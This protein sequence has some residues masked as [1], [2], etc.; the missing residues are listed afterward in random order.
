MIGEVELLKLRELIKSLMHVIRVILEDLS[1]KNIFWKHA[2]EVDLSLA[3]E[4]QG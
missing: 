2:L 4:G 1:G 3:T